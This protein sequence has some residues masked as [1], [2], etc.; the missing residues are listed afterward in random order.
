VPFKLFE[1]LKQLQLII[2]QFSFLLHRPIFIIKQMNS[3]PLDEGFN[4]KYS[5]IQNK[6]I[7]YSGD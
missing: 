6:P 5:I 7:T 4:C 1:E 2:T 3:K